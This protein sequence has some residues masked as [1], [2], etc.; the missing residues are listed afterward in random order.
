METR[1]A[2]ANLR[3]FSRQILFP[4]LKRYKEF[5]AVSISVILFVTTIKSA[6]SIPYT[7][8]QVTH[9]KNTYTQ[10]GYFSRV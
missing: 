7:Q 5:S 1:H 6:D 9:N 8:K 3:E 2:N 10:K 4:S